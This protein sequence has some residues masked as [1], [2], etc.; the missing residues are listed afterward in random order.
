MNSSPLR[1]ICQLEYT[2]AILLYFYIG[3]VD[4]HVVSLF[5][6]AII[7]RGREGQ[8]ERESVQCVHRTFSLPFHPRSLL[9]L[10]IH[11][12][13][14]CHGNRRFFWHRQKIETHSWKLF[15]L[16]YFD[17]NRLRLYIFPYVFPFLFY[18]SFDYLAPFRAFLK[19]YLLHFFFFF[20]LCSLHSF[21]LIHFS[22]FLFPECCKASSLILTHLLYP[23]I[24]IL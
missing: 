17:S 18:L 21:H 20:F 24:N 6:L 2:K 15:S 10:I 23:T 8:G 1:N 11:R 7:L 4:T 19:K 12:N 22:I 5:A 14:A 3:K 9:L 16:E 13:N